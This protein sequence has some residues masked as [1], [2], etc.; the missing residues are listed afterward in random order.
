M[1][2]ALSRSAPAARIASRAC[3][4]SILAAT[5]LAVLALGGCDGV[6]RARY[7]EMVH[8]RDS[9]RRELDEIKNG[10]SRLL[11]SAKAHLDVKRYDEARR[12]IEQLLNRHPAAVE[13]TEART[14]L[15][16]AQQGIAAR[17]A[18]ERR[19]RVAA[20]K[21]RQDSIRKHEA[22]LSR[23]LTAM[24]RSIDN[25]REITYYYDRTSPQFVG[26]ASRVVLYIAKPEA[27]SPFL[28]LSIRFRGSDW[29]FIERYTIKADD[30]TFLID[31]SGFDDV[32]RD[33]GY[34]GIWE[35]YDVP[36]ESRELDI[37]RAIIAAKRVVIRYEGRQYYHD[38]V[39][40]GEEKAAL[41]RVLDA[42]EVLQR[43][44]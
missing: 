20:E 24:R 8:E 32:E 25:V 2:I 12:D 31:A 9:L 37:I 7:N 19:T 18:L 6:P 38:R 35:W 39:I 34:S 29:L 15:T 4:A 30:E 5:L 3:S 28:R 14:L 13:T 17:E 40:G 44:R 23:A 10:S 11:A 42:Y 1:S 41:R 16:I 22:R 26:E 27:R 33:N 21:A 43:S 36:A